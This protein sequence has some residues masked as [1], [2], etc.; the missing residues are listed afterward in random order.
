SLFERYSYHKMI[1]EV[2][3]SPKLKISGQFS[4]LHYDSLLKPI[5]MIYP[6]KIIQD[7]HTIKVSR[8]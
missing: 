1:F 5:E 8:K 7:G 3:K 2:E 6:V 4:T